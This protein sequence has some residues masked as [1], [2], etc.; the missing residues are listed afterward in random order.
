MVDCLR[1]VFV[2]RFSNRDAALSMG[3]VRK[4]D[5]LWRVKVHFAWQAWDFVALKRKSFWG[6]LMASSPLSMGR[7]RKNDAFRVAGVGLCGI[8]AQSWFVFVGLWWR[9]RPCLWGKWEK[10]MCCDL[11][12]CAL[13]SVTCGVWSVRCGVWSVECGVWCGKLEVWSVQ[14][15]VWSVECEAWSVERE[16]KWSV[17][18]VVCSVRCVV[19]SV[20]FK[21]WR[22]VWSVKCGVESVKCGVRGVKR[23]VWSAVKYSPSFYRSAIFFFFLP[24]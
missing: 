5:V 2:A 8:Q 20:E 23:E 13:W 14:C 21:V 1:I 10:V 15:E 11:W 6:S 7:A 12:K 19:W 16:V 4:G 3:K 18:C 17:K 24:S 9:R 22:E